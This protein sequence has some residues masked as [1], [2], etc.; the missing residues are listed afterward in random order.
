MANE[1]GIKASI[2]P[3]K[4]STAITK[5]KRADGKP[6]TVEVKI[7]RPKELILLFWVDE[8][9]KQLAESSNGDF[10][11]KS[12]RTLFSE[13]AQTRMQNIKKSDW[14]NENIHMIHCSPIKAFHEI[15]IIVDNYIKKYGG[16]E[17][18]KTREIGI[19]SHAANDGPACYETPNIPPLPSNKNQMNILGGWDSI[20]FNWKN[21]AKKPPLCIFYGCNTGKNPDGFAHRISKLSN[22]KDVVIWGQ[23]TYSYPSFFPDYRVITVARALADKAMPELV[24]KGAN[25]IWDISG[26]TY[27]VGGRSGDGKKAL[28]ILSPNGVKLTREQLKSYPPAVVMKYFKNSSY[29]GQTH[30]GVFNDHRKN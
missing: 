15:K 12:D 24:K 19:F 21:D 14:Y 13:S 11:G 28:Y 17:K 27:M 16:K 25:T 1:K 9:D 2:P 26:Y 3:N 29:M 6:N 5:P 22:F 20:D 10:Y 23:S 4:L 30:Q 8:E 7:S 18:I